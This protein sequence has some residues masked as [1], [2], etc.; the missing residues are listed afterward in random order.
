MGDRR[1]FVENAVRHIE[2]SKNQAQNAGETAEKLMQK[3]ERA[4]LRQDHMQESIQSL[5]SRANRLSGLEKEMQRVEARF[6]QMDGLLIDLEEKQ[7]QIHAMGK[8]IEEM[9]ESGDD[10]RQELESL[11]TEA[12][13]KMD[14][15]TA[16]YQTVDALL[17]E[18]AR[19]D[20][21]GAEF[22]EN[23]APIQKG[24][25]KAGNGKAPVPEHKRNGILSLYLN[26][27]WDADLIAER[28]K[29]DPSVVR[30]VISSHSK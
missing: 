4:E 21:T 30:A 28:M 11:V 29:I 3:V 7:K 8:R 9:R 19:F 18:A 20:S 27:K 17:D 16:F 24:R 2:N 1:K 10:V 23:L 5:E 25:G 22:S 15:L 14:R 12:D 26:H 6:E 13:E